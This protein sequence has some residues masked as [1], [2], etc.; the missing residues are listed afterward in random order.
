MQRIFN[1]T[2]SF[3]GTTYPYCILRG[4]IKGLY[5]AILARQHCL[6]RSGQYS[7]AIMAILY[8]SHDSYSNAVPA[9]AYANMKSQ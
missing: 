1:L 3:Y 8:E 7:S 5:S 4:W 9:I 6:A 2:I